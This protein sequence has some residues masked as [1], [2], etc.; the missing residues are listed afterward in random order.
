MPLLPELSTWVPMTALL[1]L[2]PLKVAAVSLLTSTFTVWVPDELAK[3]VT[4]NRVLAGRVNTP[5]VAMV[6]LH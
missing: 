4:P 1:V 3:A 5:C 2:C 6:Y